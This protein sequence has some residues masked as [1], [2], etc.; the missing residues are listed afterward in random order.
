MSYLNALFELVMTLGSLGFFVANAGEFRDPGT[1]P[2]WRFAI[3]LSLFV[4][5]ISSGFFARSVLKIRREAK[6]KAGSA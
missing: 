4:G 1:H 6:N 3:A 5:L 2:S